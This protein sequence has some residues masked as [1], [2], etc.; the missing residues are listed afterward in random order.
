MEHAAELALSDLYRAKLAR[1]AATVN[2]EP[3]ARELYRA[4]PSKFATE[5]QVHL[6]HILVNLQGRT[7]EQALARARDIAKKAEA[8][9]DDFL[10]LAQQYSDDPEKRGN[11]GDIGLSSPKYL[12]PGQ[13]SEPIET[14]HGFHIVKFIERQPA[15]QLSYEQVRDNLIRS[16]RARLEKQRLDQLVMQIRSSPTVTVHTDNVEKFVTPLPDEMKGGAPA[17]AAAK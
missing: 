13:I 12:K 8:A 5:E 11:R 16:E 6:Q 14:E 17:K 4:D 3:R 7:R 1:D 10:A 2:L 15:R 9:P